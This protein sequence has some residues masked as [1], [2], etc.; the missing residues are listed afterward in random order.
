[1][2]QV[3]MCVVCFI[4]GSCVWEYIYAMYNV[5][6]DLLYNG[7]SH[8]IPSTEPAAFPMSAKENFH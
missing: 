7:V 8:A 5:V 4:K 1:M 6:F 2:I 3:R